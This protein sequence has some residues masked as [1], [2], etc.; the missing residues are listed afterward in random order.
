[1]TGNITQFVDNELVNEYNMQGKIGEGK[2][3][4][5]YKV[6]STEPSE[7]STAYAM[8]VISKEKLGV[9]MTSR[10]ESQLCLNELKVLKTLHHP[11]IVALKE[12]INDEKDKNLYLIMQ[13]MAGLNL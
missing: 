5:V 10:K 6:S 1:M 2:Y 7:K 3:G 12:V 11:H 8:K 4:K 13:H 9:N